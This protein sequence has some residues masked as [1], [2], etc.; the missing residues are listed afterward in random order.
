[1]GRKKLKVDENDLGKTVPVK[2]ILSRA[3]IQVSVSK[4]HANWLSKEVMLFWLS[5][6]LIQLKKPLKTFLN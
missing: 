5:A 6:E 1:M 4:Q 2:F 3:L